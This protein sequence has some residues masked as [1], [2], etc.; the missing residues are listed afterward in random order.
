MPI[1][2]I[3]GETEFPNPQLASPEG[4]LAVGGDLSRERLIRAYQKGIFPWYSEGEPIMWWSPDPRLVL[5]PEEVR[6]SRSLKKT[7]TKGLFRITMDRAFEKVIK[8]CART[9]RRDEAGTWIVKEMIDAYC[10]LHEAGYAH[11]VESWIGDELVG[12]LYGVSLGGCFFG[13]SMF[14]TRNDASKVAFVRLVKC[15]RQQSFCLIDCQVTTGH[16]IRFGAR[17]VPRPRFMAELSKA[18]K[19]TTLKQKWSTIW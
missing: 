8:G 18:L 11:S 1:F 2:L 7:I 13:E 4:L 14:S 10:D 12:G 3:S 5:Y 9:R 17:E 6:I 19:K 16:M 15:L